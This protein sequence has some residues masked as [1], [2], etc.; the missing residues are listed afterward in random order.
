MSR[1]RRRILFLQDR[2]MYCI[3]FIVLL[4]YSLM[5]A[6]SQKGFEVLCTHEK[7]MPKPATASIVLP[8][9]V[10]S[11]LVYGGNLYAIRHFCTWCP[12]KSWNFIYKLF[13]CL[14]AVVVVAAGAI[15]VLSTTALLLCLMR[16]LCYR[17]LPVPRYQLSL[18]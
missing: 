5:Q 8:R 14:E 9:K 18:N 2:Y 11:W 1:W 10:N 3:V 6:R 4:L 16:L 12:G 7:S 13:G 15:H 17:R